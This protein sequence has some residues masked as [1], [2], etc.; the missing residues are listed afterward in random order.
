MKRRRCLP[1]EWLMVRKKKAAHTFDLS[2]REL[3][4]LKHLPR[5]EGLDIA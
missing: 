3:V 5:G 4:V 2:P 1:I